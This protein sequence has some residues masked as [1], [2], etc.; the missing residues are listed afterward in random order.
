[1]IA[2]PKKKARKTDEGEGYSRTKAQRT[3][4]TEQDMS[5]YGLSAIDA[6]AIEYKPSG[7]K[8]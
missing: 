3:G 5:P 6:P 7:D 8:I 4:A 1:M 2:K